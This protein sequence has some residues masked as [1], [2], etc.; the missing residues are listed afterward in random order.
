M[1]SI[2]VTARRREIGAAEWKTVTVRLDFDFEKMICRVS[3]LGE[4]IAE[5]PLD[6]VSIAPDA[7]PEAAWQRI[8]DAQQD[9][10]I[11]QLIGMI[12]TDPVIGCLIKAG[13][14]TSVRQTMRCYDQTGSVTGIRNRI[15]AILACLGDNL[16]NT[17]ITATSRALRCMIWVGLGG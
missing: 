7:S 5:F 2:E 16:A 13:I 6:Y 17:A 3:Y 12:R 14:S 11:E 10:R 1:V 15:R 8:V 4:G 9:N